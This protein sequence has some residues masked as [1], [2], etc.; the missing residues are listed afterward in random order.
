MTAP[1]QTSRPAAAAAPPGPGP[2]LLRRRLTGFA[3]AAVV[4][5][6]LAAW[7]SGFGQVAAV[8]IGVIVLMYAA[9]AGGW[10]ILGGY[11]G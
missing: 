8:Q 10:N 4:I 7:G 3:V 2:G 5:A 11:A 1:G 6:L 9:L